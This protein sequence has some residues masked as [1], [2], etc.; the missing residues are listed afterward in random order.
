[1]LVEL[2]L[3]LWNTHGI[4]WIGSNPYKVAEFALAHPADISMYQEVWTSRRARLLT[5][6]SGFTAN[7]IPAGLVTSVSQAARVPVMASSEIKFKDT[8]WSQSD[9]L[10]RKGAIFMINEDFIMFINTHLDAGRD[11]E[12]AIVR[13]KQ[14]DQILK[15]ISKY[16]GPVVL[17]G[18]LNLKP[19]EPLD[20]RV[21]E[22][23]CTIGGFKVAA[24]GSNGKDFILTRGEVEVKN[25]IEHK[26]NVSDHS[27]LT[28]TISYDND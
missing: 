20:L 19:K 9:W 28:A 3:L 22:D 5:A 7:W 12:S 26:N 21:L 13:A 4:P 16:T 25:V 27:A 23:F 10:V 24:Q 11:I 15:E 1:M 8:T 18:D 2:S 14:L 17:A 6:T